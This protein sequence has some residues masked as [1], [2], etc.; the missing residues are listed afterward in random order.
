MNNP[1]R[2]YWFQETIGIHN[3]NMRLVG[4]TV[5]IV[6]SSVALYCMQKERP[7]SNNDVGEEGVIL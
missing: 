6:F 2:S 5:M 1:L 3:C 4:H 7:P